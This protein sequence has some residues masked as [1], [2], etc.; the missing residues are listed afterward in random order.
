MRHSAIG[1]ALILGQAL[2]PAPPP[3]QAQSAVPERGLASWYGE[4]HRGKIMANGEKF[5]PAKCTAASRFYPLGASVRV[6]LASAAEAERS[7]VVTIT[8][9]G[10]ARKWVERGR[11]I[12]LSEAA[13]KTLAPTNVGLVPVTVKE[14]RPAEDRS[15]P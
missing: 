7:L 4:T 1:L 8:D 6:T 5:N 13:F 9:R 10:P 12:D 2:L 3:L 15:Y 11:I 14:V